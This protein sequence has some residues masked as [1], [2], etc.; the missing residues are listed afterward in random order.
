MTRKEFVEMC[1]YHEIHYFDDEYY[2]TEEWKKASDLAE[3]EEFLFKCPYCGQL[4]TFSKLEFWEG[5][6]TVETVLEGQII[7]SH[8]YESS[9]GECL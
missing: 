4:V 6:D 5:E 8:C 7:C 3:S 2:G 9:Q 1:V